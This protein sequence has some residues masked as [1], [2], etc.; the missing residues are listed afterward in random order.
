MH[1]NAV[2]RTTEAD[3]NLARV[4]VNPLP[5][6]M[7]IKMKT[8]SAVASQMRPEF[9]AISRHY[10]RLSQF[11]VRLENYRMFSSSSSRYRRWRIWRTR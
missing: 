8:I 7:S 1:M 5:N 3:L 11:R 4:T 6:K 10:R 9:I 2:T